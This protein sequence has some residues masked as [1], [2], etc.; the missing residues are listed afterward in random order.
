MAAILSK[1]KNRITQTWV[2]EGFDGATCFFQQI[3]PETFLP[4]ARIIALLQRLLSRHL[5]TKDIIEG[6]TTLRDPFHIPIFETRREI[7]DGGVSITVGENPY[8]VATRKRR[9]YKK[10]EKS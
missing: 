7:V 2:I 9:P 10:Q 8:Y 6:S 1:K 5:T 4:D 3:L